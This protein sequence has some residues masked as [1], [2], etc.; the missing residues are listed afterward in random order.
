MGFLLGFVPAG[1]IVFIS[2]KDG[3]GGHGSDV[4][5]L[6]ALLVLGLPG[7]AI[8]SLV[9]TVCQHRGT[10]PARH[11][12]LP[13]GCLLGSIVGVVLGLFLLGDLCSSLLGWRGGTIAAGVGMIAGGMAGTLLTSGL[14][15]RP[16]NP[17]EFDT[18]N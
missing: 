18:K 8:G 9:G 13:M 14:L 4:V 11:C 1:V 5:D 15:N 3:P 7:T 16:A 2:M 10:K 17:K 12:L 6:L